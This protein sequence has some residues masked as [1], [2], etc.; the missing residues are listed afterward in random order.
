MPSTR[1]EWIEHNKQQRVAEG[2]SLAEQE[3]VQALAQ[4]VLVDKLQRASMGPATGKGRCSFIFH[5]EPTEAELHWR[6]LKKER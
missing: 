2:M 3:M 1:E 5:G 6:R 4:V